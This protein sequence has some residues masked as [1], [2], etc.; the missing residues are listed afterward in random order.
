MREEIK[1]LVESL[2]TRPSVTTEQ[3]PADR[4]VTPPPPRPAAPRPTTPSL[5]PRPVEPLAAYATLPPDVRLPEFPRAVE[6]PSD[7]SRT[8]GHRRGH[9]QILSLYLPTTLRTALEQARRERKV[10]RGVI[11]VEA[12]RHHHAY[13]VERYTPRVEPDPYFS[14]P[15]PRTR[16]VDDGVQVICNLS[17]EDARAIAQ[18]SESL[19]LSVSHA[20][21]LALS[22]EL[23]G[24]QDPGSSI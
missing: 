10:P 1:S 20:T 24:E 11:V 18:I 14:T 6:V 3:V 12:F 17:P 15:P 9:R 19:G 21:T 8:P 4:L 16:R 7:A 23:L 22:R 5:T 13:L 2:A